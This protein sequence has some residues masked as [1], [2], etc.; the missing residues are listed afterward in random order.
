M[1]Y[2]NLKA[3]IDNKGIILVRI[4]KRIIF[5]EWFAV[6]GLAMWLLFLFTTILH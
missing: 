5:F 2:L 3:Q 4:Y 1:I 6:A